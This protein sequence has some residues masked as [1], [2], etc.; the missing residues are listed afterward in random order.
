MRPGDTI[1][2]TIAET[3]TNSEMWDITVENL[4]TGKNFTT[5]TPYS[6]SY[7]TAEWIV[8]TPVVVKSGG[9]VK[10][11][12]L[13]NL[14]KSTFDNA[15]VNGANANLQESEEIQLINAKNQVISRPS[16]PSAAGDGFNVCTFSHTCAA[17]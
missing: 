6:S 4:T 7:A 1:E 16:S 12:P 5:S 15:T 13:P 8:E 14:S 2:V 11:G 10:I 9:H 17:P 3:T